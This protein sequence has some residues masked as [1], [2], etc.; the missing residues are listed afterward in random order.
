MQTAEG[1]VLRMDVAGAGSRFAAGLVD[2][3]ILMALI[4]KMTI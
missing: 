2:M 3:L 4:L 1:V